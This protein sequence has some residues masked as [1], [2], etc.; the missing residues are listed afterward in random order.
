MSTAAGRR[1]QRRPPGFRFRPESGA[2]LARRIRSR[3]GSRS[4]L[5]APHGLGRCRFSRRQPDGTHP[6]MAPDPDGQPP[7]VGSAALDSSGQQRTEQTLTQPDRRVRRTVNQHVLDQSI[8]EFSRGYAYGKALLAYLHRAEADVVR[9]ERS[10]QNRWLVHIVLPERLGAMFDIDLELLC[11]ATDYDRVEP[12]VL[13]DLHRSLRSARVDD[14]IAVLLSADPN[15]DRMTRRRP[16]GTAVLT[17]DAASLDDAPELGD[18]LASMLVTVDH[19]NVTVPITDPT[20]FFGRDSDIESARRCLRAGQHL[21]VFGLRKVGKSSLLNQVQRRMS[22]ERWAVVRIDLNGYSGRAWQAVEDLL[23]RLHGSLH[24]L[25]LKPARLRSIGPNTAILRRYWLD[26]LSMLLDVAAERTDVLIVIDEIDIVLPGRLVAAGGSDTDRSLLLAAFSQLRSIA[27]QRQSEGRS[28]P[29]VLSA[30]VDP[31]IFESPRTGRAANPLYQFSRIA[32]LEPLDR[33]AL[34]QM[35][36]VLGKRTGMRFR[37]HRLIDELR[38]EYGGHPLLTRQA[39]SFLHHHRPSREVPYNVTLEALND[40]FAAGA[41]GSPLRHAHDTLDDFSEWYPDEARC[42]ERLVAGQPV[43]VST[44]R[45]AVDY[46][47]VDASGAVRIRALT[48]RSA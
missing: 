18:A 45:H 34:A 16:G 30:G 4:R 44:V 33:E 32:F 38:D 19:F 47:I 48:R 40:A 46:G 2:P 3:D 24:G 43:D 1:R 22:E 42:I 15:A 28:Y 20:A 21:G 27:Q 29:V 11:M 10:R 12:R 7:E 13:E 41:T 23:R 35:V 31:H 5:Q 17:L 39:C 26:D 36:R 8:Q 25:G 6:S 9:V 14:E 37:D